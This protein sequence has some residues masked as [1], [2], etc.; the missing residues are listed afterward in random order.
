ME[1]FEKA[2]YLLKD[3]KGNRYHFGPGSLGFLGDIAAQ[4]G[5]KAVL[6]RDSFPGIDVFLANLKRSLANAGINLA[7]Q[8]PGAAPNCPLEDLARI[9]ASISRENPDVVISFGGGSTID[10]AKAA[11]VLQALGGNVD[12]YFG[13]GLVSEKLQQSVRKLTPHIAIQTAASSA[14]HLTKYSNIT[15]LQTGQKKLIIDEAI[16]PAE[17]L[18]DY[19]TTYQAPAGL[20]NDGGMD[21]IAHC[22]EVLY[23]VVGK[24]NY[25]KIETVAT[26]GIEMIVTCLEKAV[27]NPD[28]KQARDG[29]CLG[30]DLGGYAIMLGGTNGGHLTSF[31]LVDILSH[32]RA[33]GLMNPYYT[34]FFAPAIERPLKAVGNIF[35]KAG[36][37]SKGMEALKGRELG[38]AVA[39]AMLDFSAKVGLPTRLKDVE[40]FTDEHIARALIAAKNPQL[41]MKL[42]NM[43]IPLTAEMVDDYMKPVL[44]A[45]KEGNLAF[46]KNVKDKIS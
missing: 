24:E 12:D 15:N 7:G 20:T 23:G 22:L 2:K 30:T 4:H 26:V 11:G 21:G 8:I 3:F 41:K 36:Y 9:T 13:T 33:C 16:V 25:E 38:L 46:I 14:A 10:A 27:K 18:F 1:L 37:T 6:V 19:E 39:E 40:G 35:K 28:S 34:V 45:A 29:L 32:G 17:S 5:Q 44:E 43:P 31:S 42:Q